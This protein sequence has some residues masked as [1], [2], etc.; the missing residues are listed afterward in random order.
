MRG[1]RRTKEERHEL[2]MELERFLSMGFS[3]K[4]ACSLAELPYSTI[5][6]LCYLD[7]PLRARTR[8]LQN[9]VNVKARANII[10]SIDR[11]NIQDSKWWV[12]RFD[13]TEPQ[14]TV[15][16]GGEKEAY[17]TMLEIKQERENETLEERAERMRDLLS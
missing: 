9:T 2:F 7:E 16:Y 10:N 3:L 11:G 12:E 5:R 13:N 1:Q 6:D 4:K 8:A 15:L 17:W 14:D